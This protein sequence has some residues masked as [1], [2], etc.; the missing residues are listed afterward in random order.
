MV[1]PTQ[2]PITLGGKIILVDFMVIEDPLDF[3]IILGC[4][5]VYSMKS[6]V[7]TLFGV[8]YFPHNEIIVTVDQLEFVYPSPNTIVDQVYPSL[9]P[10]VS[11]ETTPPRVNYVA[12]YP[13]CPISTENKPLYPCLPSY[14]YVLIVYQVIYP[15]GTLD[16]IHHPIDSIE[17][18][19]M[20]SI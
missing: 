6:M 1:I 4:D 11:V 5:Y 9:I 2:T 19:Y 8:M 10:S 14:D 20:C 15:M 12:S 16:I 13:L 18:S 7:S 3:N 17:C